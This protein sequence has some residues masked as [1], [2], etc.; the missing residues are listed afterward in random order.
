MNLKKCFLGGSLL[1]FPSSSL[2]SIS[3]SIVNCS[4]SLFSVRSSIIWSTV[5]PEVPFLFSLSLL[6]ILTGSKILECVATSV[7]NSSSVYWIS[8]LSRNHWKLWGLRRRKKTIISMSCSEVS[9]GAGSSVSISKPLNCRD[10]SFSISFVMGS[11]KSTNPMTNT[12][13]HAAASHIFDMKVN[14]PIDPPQCHP[15]AGQKFIDS[16]MG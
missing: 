1:I 3:K 8:V 10:L 9:L 4:F 5:L 14:Q 15:K 13:G 2:N 6:T 7:R 12:T 16:K 11:L